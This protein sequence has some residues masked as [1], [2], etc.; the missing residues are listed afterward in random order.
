MLRGAGIVAALI[1]LAACNESSPTVRVSPS[2]PPAAATWTQDLSF[3]GEISG[4]MT[5]IVPNTADL[6]TARTGATPRPTQNYGGPG[7]YKDQAIEIQVHDADNAK[8]W[9]SMTGDA[10]AFT[11]DRTQ[12][13]GTVDATLTNADTGK[14]GSI[15]LTGNWNCKA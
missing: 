6:Q 9:L 12:Q 1:V 5:S 7:L 13:S 14:A 8:V 11:L 4:H 2:P 15:H 10:V 3:S